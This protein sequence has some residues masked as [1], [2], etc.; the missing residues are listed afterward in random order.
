M[1]FDAHHT[2]FFTQ[3]KPLWKAVSSLILTTAVLLW[4]T[5]TNPIFSMTAFGI[6][7]ILLVISYIHGNN[8]IQPVFAWTMALII[9]ATVANILLKFDQNTFYKTITRIACGVVWILWLGTQLDWISLRKILVMFRIPKSIVATIDH[10]LMHG[11]LTQK[12]WKKRRDAAQLRLGSSRLSVR[13]WGQIIGEG[14]LQAF[15]RLE[16]V[17]KNAILRSSEEKANIAKA[18]IKFDSIDVH[19]GDSLVLKDI[20]LH[21]DTGETIVICGQ[22]GAGKSSL[23]RVLAG[24][25]DHTTGTMT[26]LGLSIPAKTTLDKRLDGRIVLLVQNPEHHFIASTVLEDIM[27]GLLQRGISID[28]AR[29]SSIEI[30]AALRIDHL[31]SRPC[32]ELSF[33][34][35]RRAALAGLL[36]LKPSLLLL[37]EP[38]SGLDPVASYELRRLV[39]EIAQE[40]SMTCVWATHNLQSIPR[41]ANRVILLKKGS[42]IFDGPSAE[43]LSKPWLIQAGLMI[44]QEEENAR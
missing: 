33:G 31:L 13:T 19:R 20:N 21:V 2:L 44:P 24:L 7:M 36:V 18:A 22:S 17:E 35:Q 5:N 34:E 11:I 43:G 8:R 3:Q 28:G 4:N 6:G 40:T 29:E 38:T 12:E 14:A 30:A 1:H 37:D 32:H 39:E 26:R 10:A 42:I 25:D 27:W 9:T 16:D 15:L 23:L 41:K